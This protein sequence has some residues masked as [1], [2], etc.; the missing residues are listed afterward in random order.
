MAPGIV[1][2]MDRVSIWHGAGIADDIAA[3]QEHQAQDA[4]VPHAPDG[5]T[6]TYPE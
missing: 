1:R 4:P 3:E 2:A 6:G 5:G